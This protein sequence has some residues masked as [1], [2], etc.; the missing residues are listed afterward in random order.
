MEIKKKDIVKALEEIFYHQFQQTSKKSRNLTLLAANN[1]L[2][3]A[4]N[5]ERECERIGI[6]LHR[7]TISNVLL[8]G[9]AGCGKTAIVE[10]MAIDSIIKI[11]EEV[12]KRVNP[13]S[14]PG[15]VSE[16]V[17]EVLKKTQIPLIFDIDLC[18]FVAGTRYR[19][20]FEEKLEAILVEMK[21]SP[22]NSILFFDEAHLLTTLGSSHDST[23]AA[24]LLKPALAR[25]EIRVIGATTTDEA[26]IIKKDKALTRRFN[27]MNITSVKGNKVE[28]AKNIASTYAKYHNVGIEELPIEE[29]VNLV[30]T[31]LKSSIFPNGYINVIDETFAAAAYKG[32]NI[33][34]LPDI[35][36]TLTNMT[37]HLIVTE[38]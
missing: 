9:E 7:R 31:H 12:R 34:K 29:V 38:I 10:Q 16:I 11:C 15:E 27:F 37:G 26:E 2:T 5:R 36:A 28:I 13:D 3:K 18:S 6:T 30:N 4:Y 24:Q 22:Y 19:G 32:K 33:V 17:D 25:G 20:D 21:R 8:V 1:K 35:A 14:I 23:S